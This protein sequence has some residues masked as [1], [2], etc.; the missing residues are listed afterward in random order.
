MLIGIEGGFDT[1]E[2]KYEIEEDNSV[3]VLP[4]WTVLPTNDTN[5]PGEI[6][7]QYTPYYP[8]P[9]PYPKGKSYSLGG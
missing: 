5:L 8:R 6:Q 9:P 4:D 3:V 1:D 7:V 2:K